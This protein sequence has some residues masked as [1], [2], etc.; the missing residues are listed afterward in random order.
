MK[1]IHLENLNY[2]NMMRLNIKKTHESNLFLHNN[3]VYKIFKRNKVKSLTNKENKIEILH[4]LLKEK[5]AIY[6]LKKIYYNNSFVGYTMP[7]IAGYTLDTYTFKSPK[8]LLPLLYD[9]KREL[10][11]MHHLGIYLG[12]IH[13]GN[14][15]IDKNGMAHACD[16][17]NSS[18]LGY[19]HDCFR[20]FQEEYL[21]FH[22]ADIYLDYFAFNVVCVSLLTK[23]V[24]PYVIDQMKRNS[25]FSKKLNPNA[26]EK[27]QNFEIPEGSPYIL[28]HL[29]ES[30]T[31]KRVLSRFR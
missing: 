16:L 11:K 10:E 7:Y 5:N 9:F 8:I 4:E 23:I 20:N 1:V 19:P 6:P 27:M 26:F 3:I 28:D 12:D 21:Q 13:P 22:D 29:E 2:M 25:L 18:V 14:I 24:E 30:F 31:K 17:D 15:I